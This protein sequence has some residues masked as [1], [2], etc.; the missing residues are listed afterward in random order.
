MN[1]NPNPL[2]LTPIGSTPN[3]SAATL[4][5]NSVLRLEPASASFGGII[6]TADQ[7]LAGNK[8][9]QD[10]LGVGMTSAPLVST[11]QVGLTIDAFDPNARFIVNAENPAMG[12][13]AYF[14]AI[15]GNI[16][17]RGSYNTSN[18]ELVGVF[19]TVDYA[20]SVATTGTMF[21]TYGW[22]SSSDVN[23]GALIGAIG[24][25][26]GNN[27][28]TVT[29]AAALYS[30]GIYKGGGTAV[31]TRGYGLYIANSNG[32][33]TTAYN[34]FIE[35]TSPDTSNYFYTSNPGSLPFVVTGTNRLGVGTIS[36]V[37][38]LHVTAGGTTALVMDTSGQVGIGTTAP[39]Q[40]FQVRANSD[41]TIF[42]VTNSTT[43]LQHYHSAS[44]GAG[45]RVGFNLQ[46]RS[47]ASSS[48]VSIT[49][50][51]AYA[52]QE[53]TGAITTVAVYA[54]SVLSAG[55]PGAVTTMAGF[56]AN[57]FTTGPATTTKASF[58]S[59]AQSGGTLNAGYYAASF[60]DANFPFYYAGASGKKAVITG[61][62]QIGAG[63]DT[64]TQ[65]TY[66][67]QAGNSGYLAGGTF[68]MVARNADIIGADHPALS[69]IS[70]YV[71]TTKST[72][73]SI[74]N[75]YGS[76]HEAWLAGTLGLSGEAVGAYGRVVGN[77][78]S[79]TLTTAYGLVGD[80]VLIGTGAV[81]NIVG[82]STRARRDAGSGTISNEY[83]VKVEPLVLGTNMWGVRIGD[84]PRGTANTRRA[85]QYGD[86][87]QHQFVVEDDASFWNW[88]EGSDSGSK[89]YSLGFNINLSAYIG[90]GPNSSGP[91]PNLVTKLA[92]VQAEPWWWNQD[93]AGG[94]WA[95]G[96]WSHPRNDGTLIDLIGFAS[97]LVLQSGTV[98]N[99]IGYQVYPFV[100]NGGA[101]TN[102]FGI[103]IDPITQGTSTNRA[104]FYSAGA[105]GGTHEVRG[106]GELRSYP[107]DSTT[108]E[109]G[110]G[111]QLGSYLGSISTNNTLTNSIW[112]AYIDSETY[113]TT[114]TIADMV[115]AFGGV[116]LNHTGSAA[117]TRAIGVW[118]NIGLPTGTTTDAI[119]LYVNQ[120]QVGTPTVTN[121]YGLKI[122]SLP[123]G[124]NRWPI[125]FGSGEFTLSNS[126]YIT[127][128]GANF[129]AQNTYKGTTSI[130]AFAGGGQGSATQLS[131]E[132]NFVTT[133][134]SAGDSV[135]LPTAALGV[136]VTVH[137]TTGTSC[138]VFPASGGAINALGTNNA[139]ALGANT[140]ATFDGSSGTQW[141]T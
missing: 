118:A 136:R 49:A 82:L 65:A 93:V 81:T 61:A 130:T 112:G 83:G 43:S 2:S 94:D 108:N 58:Y 129:T 103:K 41:N 84:L 89:A 22:A 76:Y 11:V 78:T 39:N 95:I 19:G 140:T 33:A 137:N 121:A 68:G 63:T 28:G 14:E 8:W 96:F 10:K 73:A 109:W 122:A 119:S 60:A 92:G 77:Q 125:Y 100:E 37:G 36:P 25:A 70:S 4:L 48:S 80:V 6:T 32:Q 45:I 42:S 126:G 20:S 12:S 26:R 116:W 79:G 1:L 101:V 131:A 99:A 105:S 5:A 67:F 3:A 21:G 71:V 23:V 9:L 132:V 64:F 85:I 69:A 114:A 47:T 102:A 40:L 106:D 15:D 17:I 117:V 55:S 29:N 51:D 90:G 123:T 52:Q 34:L 13:P 53:G 75:I 133:V 59:S 50:L 124:T 31:V 30:Q 120:D 56:Y 54:A 134:A 127:S 111:S 38:P 86:F 46:E 138:N 139:F 62:G 107:I 110:A 74:N 141:Y 128:A 7:G 88:S 87:G 44:G 97:E 104:I 57:A 35:G 72:N 135:K 27:S 113:D 24:F 98:T 91:G 66:K 18:G 115:G 16:A